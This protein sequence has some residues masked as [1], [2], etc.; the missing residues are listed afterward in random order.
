MTLLW[1]SI[2]RRVRL[3]DITKAFSVHEHVPLVEVRSRHSPLYRKSHMYVGMSMYVCLCMFECVQVRAL[4]STILDFAIERF[5]C[6]STVKLNG[7]EKAEAARFNE[8]TAQSVQL[9]RKSHLAKGNWCYAMS[10]QIQH[11]EHSSLFNT[12]LALWYLVTLYQH[13]SKPK[14]QHLIL[15]YITYF[16][17]TTEGAHLG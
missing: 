5:T 8:Y 14:C 11:F 3:P 15:L 4:E 6:M 12:L 2:Y 10:T 1:I 13:R 7:Q 17:L 16:T 9:A